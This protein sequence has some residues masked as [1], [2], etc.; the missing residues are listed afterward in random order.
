MSAWRTFSY[1]SG[2]TIIREPLGRKKGGFL[3]IASRHGVSFGSVRSVLRKLSMVPKPDLEGEC[4]CTMRNLAIQGR[5]P[6]STG[7][8]H[9]QTE[10]KTFLKSV[11]AP[12]IA[13]DC[14]E[15]SPFACVIS[16]AL[17]TPCISSA[18]RPLFLI[19]F[20][21]FGAPTRS[22]D[23]PSKA[24]HEGLNWAALM[25]SLLVLPVPLIDQLCCHIGQGGSWH[26]GR[27]SQP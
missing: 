1:C 23:S 8:E 22:F 26:P 9:A 27:I 24:T 2:V 19:D 3:G 16:R 11:L 13:S 17:V 5:A 14:A 15:A 25:H 20:H 7:W 6:A 18:L 4:T 12:A 21:L 10:K